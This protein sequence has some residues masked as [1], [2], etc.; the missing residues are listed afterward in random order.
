MVP[1]MVSR[2]YAVV[3]RTLPCAL[4]LIV[5]GH[6]WF[7]VYTTQ[8]TP[9]LGGGFGMFSTVDDG[10]NRYLRVYLLEAQGPRGVQIPREFESHGERVQALPHVSA[11]RR[12]AAI[13]A[14][15][16]IA[17]NR[18]FSALRVEVWRTMYTTEQMRPIDRLIRS[19][20]WQT[21]HALP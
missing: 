16:F 20:D 1:S 19:I 6:Q 2:R 10:V 11:M 9:W 18:R 13:L 15:Y 7:L 21:H 17:Q 12:F 14:P 8:L 3:L 4:L 5:A